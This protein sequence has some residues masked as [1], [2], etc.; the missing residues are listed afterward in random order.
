MPIVANAEVE[1]FSILKLLRDA[2]ELGQWATDAQVSQVVIQ[3]QGHFT[4]CNL[5]QWILPVA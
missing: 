1:I 2:Q 5:A 3:G 4:K